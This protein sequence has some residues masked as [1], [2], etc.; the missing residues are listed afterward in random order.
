[1]SIAK[2]GFA[3][4]ALIRVVGLLLIATSLFAIRHLSVSI[5]MTPRHTA[6]LAEL[7]LAAVGFLGASSGS[8]LTFLGGH[9]FD[10]V[11]IS[12]R[13]ARSAAVG[14]H[15]EQSPRPLDASDDRKLEPSGLTGAAGDRRDA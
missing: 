13:W 1:M 2:R 4:S 8:A 11:E 14:L 15:Q 6:T 12:A 9:I 10:R 7:G 3:Q 5:H